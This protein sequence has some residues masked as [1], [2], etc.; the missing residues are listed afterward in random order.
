[1]S[2]N[3]VLSGGGARGLA[4]LG[5]MKALME[6]GIKVSAISGTSTGAVV[7]AFIAAGYEPEDI[8]KIFIENKLMYQIRPVLNGGLF[9]LKKWEKILLKSFPDNSFDKLNLPLTINATDINECVS[10]Y[11]SSGEL[12]LPL[13]ASCSV[14][15]F[16]EPII[17]NHRQL[18]DGGVLN[19]LPVE[20]FIDKGLKIL[21]S[22]ANP[23]TFIE[24][25]DSVF[26]IFERSV[27]LSLRDNT[28][29][30]KKLAHIVLEPDGLTN[31]HLFDLDKAAE[32]FDVGYKY[33]IARR[34]E[35]EQLA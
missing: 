16:F 21:A 1:M 12:V 9:R 2:I 32:I 24:N 35:L 3:L 11:F 31:F 15:G 4:H 8:L 17:I 18:L 6:L 5:I 10:V 13:L 23:L 14:P 30:R 27:Q 7:G 25:I 19:N 26:M 29:K 34:A 28:T 22:H 33:A 20:P